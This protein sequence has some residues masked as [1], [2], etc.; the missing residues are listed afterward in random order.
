MSREVYDINFNSETLNSD[1]NSVS[2]SSG[3][4]KVI[5]ELLAISLRDE[6]LGYESECLNQSWIHDFWE[7]LYLENT[8]DEDAT[9]MEPCVP[10]KKACMCRPPGPSFEYFYFYP[11]VI[12]DFGI[13]I[14]FTIFQFE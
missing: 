11:D 10:C 1:T 5:M 14:S 13:R 7:R 4:V 3:S 8:N 6:V 2:S 9:I 12:E